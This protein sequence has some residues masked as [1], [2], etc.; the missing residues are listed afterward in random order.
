M[1]SALILALIIILILLSIL[2]QHH[3]QPLVSAFSKDGKLPSEVY[4][5]L[6]DSSGADFILCLSEI[7]TRFDIILSTTKIEY[8][9]FPLIFNS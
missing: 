9:L 4:V 1:G 7:G 2:S 5:F 6:T 8:S 3:I